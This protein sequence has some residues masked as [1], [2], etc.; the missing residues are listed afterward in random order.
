[1][2]E[3]TVGQA[4]H[5]LSQHTVIDTGSERVSERNEQTDRFHKPPRWASVK[6]LDSV[7]YTRGNRHPGTMFS[8]VSLLELYRFQEGKNNY[9]EIRV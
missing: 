2:A 4:Q 3:E 5:Y 7:C 6:Q 9:S 8:G 1:M